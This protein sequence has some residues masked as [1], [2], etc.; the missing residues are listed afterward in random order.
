MSGTV[1]STYARYYDLL[2]QD[3]DYA[4]ESDYVSALLRRFHPEVGSVLELGSGTGR[5]AALLAEKGYQVL[6]VE[7]SAEMLARARA[8][9]R[10][11]GARQAAGPHSPPEFVEGDIRSVRIDRGFD[12]AISLFH[13]ISYQ[14]ANADLLQALETVRRH[15]RKG[16]L[17]VFDVWY[18]PAVLTDPPSTRVKR[19]A[20]ELIEV[21]R[22]A[23][24][25]LLPNSNLVEVNYHV[26]VRTKATGSV[27][28]TREKHEMRYLFVPEIDLLLG[29]SGFERLHAEEWLTGRTPGCGTW[30]VCFVARRL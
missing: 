8:L 12:A 16:G 23:E 5:H 6:G 10:A 30:G 13:V 9:I 22:L 19:M 1:F 18:G 20:D 14:T 21:T 29:Q 11:S 25:V 27:S 7:R 3:K 15:V 2:Y 28:E 24:P 26:F 4:R 17:F